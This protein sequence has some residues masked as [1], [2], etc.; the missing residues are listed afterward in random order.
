VLYNVIKNISSTAVGID[1]IS[2]RMI[3]PLVN[4][5][6]SSICHLLIFMSSICHL[7]NYSLQNS[8]FPDTWKRSLI[9][10]V[11]KV[12]L[13]QSASDFQPIS[14]LPVLAKIIEKV[15]YDQILLFINEN[16]ICDPLQSGF[17]K[18]H[19]TGMAL[20]RISEDI[21]LA[22]GRVEVIVM[23]LLDFNKAFDS[24][25]HEILLKK[26]SCINFTSS[27]VSWFASLLSNR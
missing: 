12:P 18:F 22:L 14:I 1:G 3:K 25:N 9:T 8:T 6:L 20:L 13:P 19:S 11:P 26:L 5:L 10:P 17:R 21:R 15:V 2:I 16:D 27:V 7:L 23:V 24:V 4:V